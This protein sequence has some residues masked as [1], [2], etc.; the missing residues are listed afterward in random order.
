MKIGNGWKL[1]A[2]QT[3][4]EKKIGSTIYYIYTD[5]DGT[6]HYFYEDEEKAGTFMDEDNLGL[7]VTKMALFIP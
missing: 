4:V 5:G 7:S 2:Q 1:N 6:E 3:I